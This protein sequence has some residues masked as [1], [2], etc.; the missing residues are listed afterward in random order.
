MVKA[1]VLCCATGLFVAIALQ[2][3]FRGR[4]VRRAAA[5]RLQTL[6]RGR[7]ARRVA[8]DTKDA[9]DAVESK[10]ELRCLIGE[11]AVKVGRLVKKD[12]P[13]TRLLERK[14]KDKEESFLAL[15]YHACS[16]DER[17]WI[18][19]NFLK[20]SKQIIDFYSSIVSK[21]GKHQTYAQMC[22]SIQ[23]CRC[24]TKDGKMY[25]KVFCWKEIRWFYMKSCDTKEQDPLAFVVP[26][27]LKLSQ[28]GFSEAQ[29]RI[30]IHK[31]FPFASEKRLTPF[32]GMEDTVLEMYDWYTIFKVGQKYF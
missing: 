14:I 1:F 12:G 5:I 31:M 27:C 20:E 21:Q 10:L 16:M 6:F 22:A 11:V 24:F 25:W 3:L 19:T 9:K 30:T 29:I 15:M 13:S 4:Q 18:L 7:Q 17:K 23:D 26:W 8:A 32:P 28:Q 2:A